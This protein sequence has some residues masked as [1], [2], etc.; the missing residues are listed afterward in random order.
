MRGVVAALFAGCEHRRRNLRSLH[1]PR[2]NDDAFCGSNSMPHHSC[3][4]TARPLGHVPAKPEHSLFG[5]KIDGVM[6]PA[7]V[8]EIGHGRHV[9]SSLMKVALRA[10]VHSVDAMVA[11]NE[12]CSARQSSP[13]QGSPTH[14]SVRAS[15]SET[16][17]RIVPN[18]NMADSATNE[19][20]NMQML[21]SAAIEATVRETLL[22]GLCL[23]PVH[24]FSRPA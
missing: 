21:R 6:M 11:T 16:V 17:L 15:A 3:Q 22:V 24:L 1:P 18:R 12:I 14:A 20:Y 5:R 7:L 23:H 13:D 2:P 8:N 9:P 10:R 4:F 19:Y